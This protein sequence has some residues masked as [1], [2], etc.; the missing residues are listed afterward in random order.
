MRDSSKSIPHTP[1]SCQYFFESFLTFLYRLFS[2]PLRSPSKNACIY[3]HLF[4]VLS[5][6]FDNF[7]WQFLLNTSLS[8]LVAGCFCGRR[9]KLH[10]MLY[11]ISLLCP[12]VYMWGY[13]LAC[14]SKH[15]VSLSAGYRHIEPKVYRICRKAN[16]SPFCLHKKEQ[17]VFSG[18]LFYL[19]YILYRIFRL[20]INP[21]GRFY[22]LI[23]EFPAIAHCEL[24]IAHCF[25]LA[26]RHS[27]LERKESKELLLF[28]I[29]T[30]ALLLRLC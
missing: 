11:V 24:R 26:A 22:P 30:N 18:L 8:I 25:L 10:H 14:L 1:I 9:P 15:I 16:I 29:H 3:Y 2:H 5:T 27:F 12:L 19:Y 21:A 23:P 4:L 20:H 13:S 17:S 28:F 6:V 7:F